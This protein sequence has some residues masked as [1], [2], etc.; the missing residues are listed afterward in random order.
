MQRGRVHIYMLLLAQTVEISKLVDTFF[1]QVQSEF[2][3]HLAT[4]ATNVLLQK[5][6]EIKTQKRADIAEERNTTEMVIQLK[7]FYV[8]ILWARRN[9]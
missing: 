6:R 8:S 5:T 3:H 7:L 1:L 9:K 2:D 4:H